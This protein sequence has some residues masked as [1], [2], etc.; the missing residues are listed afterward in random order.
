MTTENKTFDAGAADESSRKDALREQLRRGQERMREL[1]AQGWKPVHKNPVEQAHEKPGS[2]KAAIK[3]FCWLCVGADAD[4][5]AKFRVR[6]CAVGA[7]C[8][9]FQHRP[10]Q[11]V[12]GG[13]SLNEDGV[14][15]AEGDSEDTSEE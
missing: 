11:H 12:K 6:D 1:R 13:V 10:W 5:G 7:K 2:M 8:P 14:L 4:P 3:A 15:A 9:L